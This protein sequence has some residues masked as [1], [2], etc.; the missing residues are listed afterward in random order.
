MDHQPDEPV[1]RCD[2][3]PLEGGLTQCSPAEKDCLIVSQ[4]VNRAHGYRHT[5]RVQSDS[6]PAPRI[7]FNSAT[8][9]IIEFHKVTYIF[10]C[11]QRERSNLRIVGIG[12]LDRDS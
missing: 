2:R 10:V 7:M 5:M 11:L 9:L 4:A 8:C 12:G 3:S 6:F 1:G